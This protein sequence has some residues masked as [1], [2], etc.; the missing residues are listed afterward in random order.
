MPAALRI[1]VIGEGTCSKRTAALARRVGAEVARAGAVLFSGG[2]GGVME[3]AS[4]R[5]AR[6]RGDPGHPCRPERA[7]LPP[8]A[9]VIPVRV[10]S[11]AKRFGTVEALRGVSLEFAAG[12]LTA[13]L[14]PSGCGKT[15]LR[16]AITG[17][18]AVD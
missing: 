12:K 11:V 4:R 9:L 10:E 14:G 13:I 1:G 16:R 2:R 15:T 8:L 7:R 3:A 17:F 6:G 18:V 5:H